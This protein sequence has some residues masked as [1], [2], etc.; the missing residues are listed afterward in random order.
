MGPD[1]L[2]FLTDANE[3]VLS[4]G[5]IAELGRRNRAGAIINCI[6]FGVGPF[7]G[8]DNFLMR[9]ARQNRGQHVYVDVTALGR[10]P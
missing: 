2:F 5:D 4:P 10:E 3:P 7:S 9:L 8:G 1:V 6:E